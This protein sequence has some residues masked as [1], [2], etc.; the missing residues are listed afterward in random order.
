MVALLVAAPLGTPFQFATRPRDSAPRPAAIGEAFKPLPAPPPADPLVVALGE[1]LFKDPRLSRDNTRSCASCHDLATNG[2][3]AGSHDIGLDGQPLPLN[4]LTVFNAALSF[5]LGWEGKHSDLEKQAVASLTNPQIMGTT[6]PEVLRK[7]EAD[8]AMVNRFLAAYGRPPDAQSL[9]HA[10]ATFQ[11]SL[12]TPGSRFDRWLAGTTDALNEQEQNGYA[13]F[14]ALGC[15]SC[16]QGLSIGGNLFQRQGIFRPLA[17]PTPEILRVPSLRNVAATP[18]YF[19]D[20]SSPD[21]EDAVRKMGIAQLNTTLTDEQTE[22]I[23]AFLRSLTGEFKGQPV[24][25]RQ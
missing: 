6:I 1:L 15:A 2:A 4:T 23:I 20:G 17:S 16:H 19:H 5:R 12:I 9:L 14:K 21:L 22:A 8:T 18:P 25:G 7:L 24:R 13:L 10:L 11:R 3:G